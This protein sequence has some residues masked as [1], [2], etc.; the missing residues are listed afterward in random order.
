MLAQV[1]DV[2]FQYSHTIGRREWNG[3]TGFAVPSAL[4]LGEG[5]RIY[6]V[7]RSIESKA[8]G[9]R[10]TI[11]TI[12]EE[13]I[14][15]FGS[16][17]TMEGIDQASLP[18]GSLVWPTSIALDKKGNVYI[19]DEWLSLVSIFDSN[20][21]WVGKWGTRGNGDGELDRPSGLA[22]DQ[23]DNL[24]IVDSRNNRIQ[25]LTK[26]GKFLSKWGKTGS[27][28]G[29]FNRPWG[30][31]ID[32]EGYVYVADW[33]NDRIQKF[34][35]DGRFIMKFGASGSGDGQFNGPTGKAG[36]G[37]G[38]IYVP[39][40]YND[41]LQI[42]DAQ[43]KFITKITGDATLS[44]WGEMKLVAMPD[45]REARKVSEDM[46]TEKLMLAP[47]AV[48][49]D[50]QGRVLILESGRHRIQVYQKVTS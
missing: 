49:V 19:A 27:G 40:W 11:C 43:G 18:N 48:D 5:D 2:T 26:D 6:V 47:V 15:D 36:D 30:I 38:W 46:A 37:E 50:N 9:K 14:G 1:Q 7:N 13:Y 32:H 29:E 10:V 16:G 17:A 12:G 8:Y 42:F 41:R 3:G 35:A 33:R 31:D 28:N 21:D 20:G 23:Q 45:V 24:Y 25:K 4:A 44:K 39:D 34:S 22:F